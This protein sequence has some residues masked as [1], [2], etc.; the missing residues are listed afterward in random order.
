[1]E[2]PLESTMLLEEEASLP[3]ERTIYGNAVSGAFRTS[4]PFNTV[5]VSGRVRM[6]SGGTWAITW[7]LTGGSTSS[8]HS[9]VL[10]HID[11][12]PGGPRILRTCTDR[13]LTCLS[14]NATGRT[15]RHAVEVRFCGDRKDDGVGMKCTAFSKV[16]NF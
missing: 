10:Q 5:T 14:L 15:L 12:R 3:E 9:Y 6:D 13:S 2:L 4:N 1:M 8:F 16:Q 11:R 7:N